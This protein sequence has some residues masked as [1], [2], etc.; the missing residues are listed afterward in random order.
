MVIFARWRPKWKNL[1]IAAAIIASLTAVGQ[2]VAKHSE[3][4]VNR[5]LN[6][7][8]E[9]TTSLEKS[10]ENIYQ[11]LEGSITYKSLAERFF[12]QQE[13]RKAKENYL[14]ALGLLSQCK[15]SLDGIVEGEEHRMVVVDT[16]APSSK[17]RE[18]V[19][20]TNGKIRTLKQR[21]TNEIQG[22]NDKLG[23]I[24]QQK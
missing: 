8:I 15:T 6:K 24:E 1:A 2:Q 21:I 20:A 7:V 11:L 10:M 19:R 13:F 23:A 14:A 3:S 17:I 9:Q 4:T 12:A 18:Q 16:F 5:E 22:I